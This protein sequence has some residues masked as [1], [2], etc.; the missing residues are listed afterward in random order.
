MTILVGTGFLEKVA[1]ADL[2]A[3]SLK[4]RIVFYLEEVVFWLETRKMIA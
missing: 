2:I 4:C 3:T 1:G